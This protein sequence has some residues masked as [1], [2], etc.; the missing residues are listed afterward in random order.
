MRLFLSSDG[1][2][3]FPERLID[4]VGEGGRILVTE[5]ALDNVGADYVAR[6]KVLVYD[7]FKDLTDRGF[8]VEPLDL[9]TY[10]KNN[11]GLADRIDQ[12]EMVFATGGNT[13]L[14]RRA[15]RQSGLDDLLLDR[16]AADKIVYG[17][18]SAGACIASPSLKGIELCDDPHDVTADYNPAV[19]WNGLGLVPYSIVPHYKS[20]HPESA[21]MEQEVAYLRAHGV[22]YETLADGDVVIVDGGALEV[23]RV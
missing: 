10:F 7:I 20:E 9:R 6:Y 11:D 5:N 4:L 17:G 15:M 13:F 19:I 22:P 23:L 8:D 1:L 16:L 3:A 21:V 2:S 14:L 12:A 18:W